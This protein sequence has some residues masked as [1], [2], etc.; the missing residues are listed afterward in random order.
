MSKEGNV[1][2]LRIING[3]ICDQ[4]GNPYCFEKTPEELEQARQ[5]DKETLEERRT[6]VY[7]PGL[8][9]AKQS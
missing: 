7:H 4:S 5:K 2:H 6:F 9:R 3:V 8:G 1:S